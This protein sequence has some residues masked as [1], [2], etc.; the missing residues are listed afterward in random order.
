[1]RRGFISVHDQASD[2]RAAL[3]RDPLCD[4]SIRGIL[5]IRGELLE[6]RL[7]RASESND[8][9]RGNGSVFTHRTNGPASP[10]PF[11]RPVAHL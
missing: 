9:A 7:G 6:N 11:I 8:P 1:M 5:L 3:V 4:V 2:R 10:A